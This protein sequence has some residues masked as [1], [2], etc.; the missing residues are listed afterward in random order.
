MKCNHKWVDM[1]DGSLDKFCLRCSNKAMQAVSI[2]VEINLPSPNTFAMAPMRA[3]GFNGPTTLKIEDKVIEHLH[4]SIMR[5]KGREYSP[6]IKI[7]LY[8]GLRT[9]GGLSKNTQVI[10]I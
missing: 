1:E 6:P 5:L 9:E 8:R 3:T 7:S 2:S 10:F 4:N